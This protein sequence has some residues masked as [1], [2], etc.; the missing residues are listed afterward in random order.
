MFQKLIYIALAGA[1]GTLMRYW[2]SGLVQKNITFSFP[3][4]T[5]TVNIV[6]CLFFGLL[7][8]FLENRLTITGQMRTVIFLGF[9]GGFTTFSSFA[10][11]TAQMLD[12][13]QWM[14][15]SINIVVQ[16]LLGVIGMIIGLAIG[17]FI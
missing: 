7:W 13:S 8:A 10:F 4:G 6:G 12:E 9:F 14:W 16:N 17:K 15:A 11:E 2:L 3:L 5:A 1:F